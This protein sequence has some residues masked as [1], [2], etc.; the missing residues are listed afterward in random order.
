[1]QLFGVSSLVLAR[2]LPIIL[3][4]NQI[5]QTRR[6]KAKQASA[7]RTATQFPPLILIV[8][9]LL[10]PAYDSG[11]VFTSHVTPT[12]RCAGAPVLHF[13]HLNSSYSFCRS[14]NNLLFQLFRACNRQRA[15]SLSFSIA[16]QQILS[17][18]VLRL[19]VPRNRRRPFTIHECSATAIT[20]RYR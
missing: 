15:A 10:N 17:G 2:S 13:H 18:W 19:S 8:R 9:V 20:C 6:Q 14:V 5:A 4:A 1:M 12:P 11:E 3:F 16:F 7:E